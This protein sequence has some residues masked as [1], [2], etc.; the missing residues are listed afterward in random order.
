M[1]KCL[2]VINEISGKGSLVDEKKLIDLYSKDYEVDI[3]RIVDETTL[4]SGKGYDLVIACGG[5]GTLNNVINGELDKHTEVIYY[6]FG[7]FNETDKGKGRNLRTAGDQAQLK[8]YATANDKIFSYVLAAG[9]FTSLG[10][11]VDTDIKKKFGIFAYFTKVVSV[12][13]VH[14]IRAKVTIDNKTYLNNYTLMMVIDSKRCFGFHFN[15]LYRPDNGKVQVLL[16]K[17]PGRKDNFR[18][19][20]KMFFPF[21][22]AFFVG[23]DKEYE[24]KNIIFKSAEKVT[25]ELEGKETFNIDGE[26]MDFNGKID[27]NVNATTKGIYFRNPKEVKKRFLRLR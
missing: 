15:R 6:S 8:E 14:S 17:S 27:V 10:Y 12:Y 3:T 5:D 16:I 2:I 25:I 20:V 22:R 7:T 26:A 1:K 21:F 4:W 24:S 18:N 23:F 9:S 13:K 19:K 11:V